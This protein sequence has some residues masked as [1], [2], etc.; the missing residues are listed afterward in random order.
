MHVHPTIPPLPTLI[1][2]LPMHEHSKSNRAEQFSPWTLAVFLAGKPFKW[3]W[4]DSQFLK[5]LDVLINIS[6]KVTIGRSPHCCSL[7]V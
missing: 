2:G 6:H 3:N 4:G 1:R 7:S 5:W